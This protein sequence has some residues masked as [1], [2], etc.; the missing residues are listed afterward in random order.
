[1][2]SNAAPDYL[3]LARQGL[4]Q[5]DKPKKVIVVGAGMAGLTAAYEL[6]RAGHDP[7][8]IEAQE[9]VGGRILTLRSPFTPGLYGE[10]GAMRIPRAHDLTMAYIEKFN[11]KLLPFTMSNPQAYCY[12]NGTRHRLADVNADP[13]C[14]GFELKEN[15]RGKTASQLFDAAIAPMIEMIN[16]R[17]EDAWDELNT[18]YD[19]YST[20]DFLW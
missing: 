6:L 19:K 14:L 1:M 3:G 17:G 16:A 9:R 2:S 12:L 5:T 11:L 18:R 7:L 15:E 4:P 13:D 20:R 10:A 8:V